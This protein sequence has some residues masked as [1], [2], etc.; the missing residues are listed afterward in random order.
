VGLASSRRCRLLGSN[1]APSTTAAVNC[2]AN[3]MLTRYAAGS[4]ALQ[5][6]H[7]ATAAS[8]VL[9]PLEALGK[10]PA[11][12]LLSPLPLFLRDSGT[13]MIQ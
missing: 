2:S 5:R 3:R 8:M 1:G 6:S 4:R 12:K 9:L 13:Y 7:S 11:S 10:L